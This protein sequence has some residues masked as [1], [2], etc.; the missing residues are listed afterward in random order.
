MEKIRKY[1]L[2]ITLFV[3]LIFMGIGFKGYWN[4]PVNFVFNP[5]WDGQHS[6]FTYLSHL[7]Q[8]K[9]KGLTLLQ[10]QN[11]PFGDYILYQDNALVFSVPIKLIS[12]YVIDLKPYKYAVYTFCHIL[13]IFFCTLFLFLIFKR[14]IKNPWLHF[15]ASIALAWINPQILR[16]EFGHNSLS[17]SWVLVGAIYWLIRLYEEKKTTNKWYFGLTFWVIFCSFCHFYY[18]PLLAT[19][20]LPTHVIA[21]WFQSTATSLKEKIQQILLPSAKIVGVFAAAYIFIFSIIKLVDKYNHLRS[22]STDGYDNL[23]WKFNVSYAFSSY[24]FIRFPWFIRNMN[25]PFYESSAY[26]GGFVLFLFTLLFLLRIFAKNLILKSSEWIEESYAPLWKGFCAAALITLF[27]SLGDNYPIFDGAYN[28]KNY[29]N[30]FLYLNYL[31]S[32]FTQFRCLSRFLW[33]WWWLLGI[34]SVVLVDRYVQLTQNQ[35][36]KY[37]FLGLT[38]FLGLDTYDFL[39]YFN[40]KNTKD[41]IIS[42]ET[43][44]ELKKRFEG[45]DA[46]QFQAMLPLPYYHVGVASRNYTID[47][48]QFEYVEANALS[49]FTHLP[50][51]AM[52]NARS[53]DIHNKALFSMFC[54]NEVSPILLEK[55]NEKPVLVIVR[56]ASLNADSTSNNPFIPPADVKPAHNVGL[57]GHRLVQRY[58]MEK[59]KEDERYAYYRWYIKRDYKARADVSKFPEKLV[60]ET[61]GK[62]KENK[63]WSDLIA[64]KANEQGASLDSVMR[65]EAVYW[66]DA[67]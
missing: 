19:L 30:P 46:T 31:S 37:V 13:G 62:I 18:L 7:L 42:A 56:K 65:K 14:F 4:D 10:Q 24:H 29:L 32:I 57:Y 53:V 12:D 28:A 1:L 26:L 20:I 67:N 39:T 11:Y 9:E 40:G 47:G 22:T 5:Y 64:K 66:L 35:G 16:L 58:P 27:I 55:M 45:I 3:Q 63:E 43:T 44:Q 60:Q 59:L 61:I 15:A 21:E 49:H 50:T 48:N 23:A 36:L 38:L 54:E 51:M 17:Y 52:Q 2:F 33:I 34:F 8:P 6:N 41:N 25:L